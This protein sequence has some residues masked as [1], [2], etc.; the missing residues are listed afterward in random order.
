MEYLVSYMSRLGQPMKTPCQ[1]EEEKPR[2]LPLLYLSGDAAPFQPP[3]L[4]PNAYAAGSRA[5]LPVHD[6]APALCEQLQPRLQLRQQQRALQH[7]KGDRLL[8]PVES[9]A[10]IFGDYGCVDVSLEKQRLT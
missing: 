10:A 1:Y 8:L 4:V 9:L 3:P 7:P 2:F 5:F 6:G